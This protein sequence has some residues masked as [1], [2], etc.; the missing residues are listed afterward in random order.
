MGRARGKQSAEVAAQTRQ[1]ILDAAGRQFAARGF[2]AASLRDIA[3][4][5]GTTHGLIRHYFGTKD[6]LWRAVVE[7][8]I[9]R[10]AARQLPLLASLN[11]ADPIALLKAI[12]TELMRQ[13]AEM[14]QVARLLL[15]D[16]TEPG[17]RLDYLAEQI[18]PIH[19]AVSPV[20]ERA[21]KAGHLQTHDPDSFFVFLLMV[22]SVPFGLA[23]FTNK[24]TGEDIRTE[25]GVETHI[26]RV[27]VTLFG[28]A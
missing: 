12:A 5:A 6:E 2:R 23:E 24:F 9:N 3:A 16:C 8:F 10:V 18:R 4:D 1:N 20:F 14:P 13:S 27:L 22:G 25:Q 17:P 19:L 21:R 26:H 7:D 28:G 15:L 11:D